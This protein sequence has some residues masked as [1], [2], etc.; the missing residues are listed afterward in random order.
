MAKEQVVQPG[1][2]AIS[3]IAPGTKVHGDIDTDGTLRV[4]FMRTRPA[5]IGEHTIAEK[6]GDM[7]LEACNLGGDRLLVAVYQLAQ[8]LGVELRRERRRS[9]EIDEHDGELTAQ[10]VGRVSGDSAGHSVGAPRKHAGQSAWR[11][12]AAAQLHLPIMAAI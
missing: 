7:P 9:D 4:V 10:A 8:L 3:I 1:T 2:S 11:A 12:P 5:E 6:L